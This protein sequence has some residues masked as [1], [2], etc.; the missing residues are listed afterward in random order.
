MKREAKIL[1][2]KSIESLMLGIEHFNRPSDFG[3]HEAVL[4]LVDRAFELLLKGVIIHKGGRIRE[5]YA[6]DT[7]GFDKC[8]RKCV[9]DKSLKCLSE[10]QTLTIQILNS[11]RDAAQHYILSLS[12]QQLYTYTQAGVTLFGDILQRVFGQRLRDHLP[13]RVLP[14]SS[15]PPKDL[16]AIIET[17]FRKVKRLVQPHSRRTFDAVAKLRSLAIVESSLQGERAQPS[18]LELF[19]LIQHIKNGQG[20][21]SLFPGVAK[22]NLTTEGTGLNINVRLTKREGDPVHLVPE[23]TPGATVVAVKRVDELGF[24]SFGLTDLA[25]RLGISS[26]KTLALIKHCDLQSSSE[27]FKEIRV[28]KVSFKRYSQKALA[29]LKRDLAVVDMEKVWLKHKPVTRKRRSQ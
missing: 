16:H 6:K 24:Y 9:S 21:R 22:L 27:F 10:E 28:G 8:V 2:N 20:W 5:P 17:E 14:V 26:P 3:R 19:R 29:R 11:L 12:E 4:I 25:E 15:D 1:K 7:I 18:Q 23:G 13:E